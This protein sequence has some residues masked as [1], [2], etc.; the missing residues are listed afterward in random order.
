MAPT[1]TKAEAASHIGGGGG[2]VGGGGVGGAGGGGSAG[3]G[4]GRAE[5][6]ELFLRYEAWKTAYNA[7]DL[8]DAVRH[9][10]H[11]AA[12]PPPAVLQPHTS[13][14][15]AAPHLLPRCSPTPPAV[16][17]GPTYDLM[18]LGLCR[19][20][21]VPRLRLATRV[22][23]GPGLRTGAAH[24]LRAEVGRLPRAAH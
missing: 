3:G 18:L 21:A 1:F 17:R 19:G 7:Y 5:V 15:A 12:A 24:L 6:Y 2:G 4:G 23:P 10:L 13:C 11:R 16:R 9:T 20:P 14:R 22:L 8:M